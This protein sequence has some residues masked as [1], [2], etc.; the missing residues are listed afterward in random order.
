MRCRA[1]DASALSKREAAFLNSEPVRRASGRRAPA[2]ATC[3]ATMWALSWGHSPPSAD[4]ALREEWFADPR[5]VFM[6]QDKGLVL[7][8]VGCRGLTRSFARSHRREERRAL[9]G[10]LLALK[11][12]DATTATDGLASDA[13][14]MDC[15]AWL[16]EN[17]A[18]WERRVAAPMRR[19]EPILG[20]R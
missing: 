8:G 9:V 14:R 5:H 6:E 12:H 16:R 2:C 20:D 18:A 17:H 11:L 3:G 15:A 10:P 4:D 7:S 19:I 13:E 1:N